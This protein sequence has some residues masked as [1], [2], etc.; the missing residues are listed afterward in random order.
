MLGHYY[1]REAL[2]QG[3]ADGSIMIIVATDAPL[4]DRNLARL[5]RRAFAGLARTGAAFAD[6]SGDYAIAFSTAEPCGERP[7]AAPGWPP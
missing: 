6:G 7:N 4:S 5:A 1:L 3:N 2:D